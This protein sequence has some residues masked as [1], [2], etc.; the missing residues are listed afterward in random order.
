MKLRT[1][2]VILLLTLLL[3][4]TAPIQ[5]SQNSGD[6]ELDAVIETALRRHDVPGASVAVM[7]NGVV[8]WAR[9]YGLADTEQAIPADLDTVFDSASVAKPVT[10]WGI[11]TLVEEGILDLDLPIAQYVDR[12][13]LPPSE[14]NEEMVTIR[15]ILSHTAG[16][17]TDGDVGV[18]PGAYVP[19]I[20]EAMDGA[21]LGMR[22]LHIAYPPGDDYHYSSVGYTLLELAVEEAT[23]ESFAEYMQ[24]EVLDPLGMTNSGLRLNGR[25]ARPCRHRP[26]LVQQPSARIPIFHAGSRWTTHHPH[27]PGP[28]HGRPYA[29]SKRRTNRP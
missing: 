14:Y 15:R 18:E 24:R 7:E 23:G 17:S 28:I 19:T 12:W 4:T 11:M 26:R 5:A 2:L 29:W 20:E 9:G 3:V 1:P 16:L 13:Q 8:S 21:V 27:R 22:A 6:S 10:A 25:I